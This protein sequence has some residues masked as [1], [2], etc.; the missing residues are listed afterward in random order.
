[1]QFHRVTLLALTIQS[2]VAAP[3]IG[4][5]IFEDMVLVA[6]YLLESLASNS[7]AQVAGGD[8]LN[9]IRHAEESTS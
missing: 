9:P 3:A 2:R 5:G 7:K 6:G 4:S 8:D 1:M